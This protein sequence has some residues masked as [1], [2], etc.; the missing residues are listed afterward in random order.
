MRIR[1]KIGR[2]GLAA[3]A[4]ALTA[5]SAISPADAA[6]LTLTEALQAAA[7]NIDVAIAS[8]AAAAAQ[9]DVAAADHAP[10]PQLTAKLSQIDLQNGVGP[11]NLLRDKRIDKS[12]GLDWTWERGDKR[13]LRTEAA[14][15]AASAAAADVDDVRLQQMLAAQ[16]AFFDLLTA[17]ERLADVSSIAQGAQQLASTA[18][19]REQAGDL[20]V[21]DAARA[22]IEAQRALADTLS[23]R[24]DV[25]R[26]RS[27]LA[28][29]TGLPAAGLEASGDWPA[30][31]PDMSLAPAANWPGELLDQRADVRAAAE[32]VRAA[33][34]ALEGA[35]ALR[36]TDVTWG[37]SVDHYPG[38]ST[39][40]VELRLQVPLQWGYRYEGENERARA[41]LDQARDQLEKTRRAAASELQQLRDAVQA[42]ALRSRSYGDEIVPRSRQVLQRAETAYAKGAMP[43]GDLLDARRTLRATLLEALAV[44]AELAKAVAAWQLRTTPIDRFLSAAP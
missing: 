26:A 44:R 8:R 17:Q 10:L 28:L 18:A 19:R 41:Q 37:A 29:Q 20:A 13:G 7:R 30:A 4:L 33:E 39:R 43:L 5:L 24:Q 25:Q 6:A 11:G 40:Q 9:A 21:Q 32:R 3:A 2:P 1:H 23:A 31:P 14:R 38:T 15:R 35:R 42:A 27:L 12:V 36:S 16:A 34:A 22:G